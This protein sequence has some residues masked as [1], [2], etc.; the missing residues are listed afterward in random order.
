MSSIVAGLDGIT[1]RLAALADNPD[2]P[3]ETLVLGLSTLTTA[4]EL[5]VS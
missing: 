1:S 5:Y 2:I 3:Y 4:F